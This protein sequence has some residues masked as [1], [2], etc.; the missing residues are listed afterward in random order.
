MIWLGLGSG[1]VFLVLSRPI[2]WGM[3]GVK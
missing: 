1:L 3:H 2:S